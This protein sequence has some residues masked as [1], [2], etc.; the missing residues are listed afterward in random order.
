ML[1]QLDRLLGV[2]GLQHVDFG[3]IP[4]GL[5]LPTT[6]QNG[7]ILFDDVAVVETFVGETTYRGAEVDVLARAM[8]RLMAEA[9]RGEEAR[10]LVL[11]AVDDLR[12]RPEP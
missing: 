3:I 5:P 12:S 6:P 2:F 9:S 10:H 8:D 4:F 7:F 1:A 11:R